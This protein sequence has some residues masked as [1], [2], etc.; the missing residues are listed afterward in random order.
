MIVRTLDSA[1]GDIIA[2]ARSINRERIGWGDRFFNEYQR[3]AELIERYPQL[4]S[5]VEDGLPPHEIRNAIF[6]RFDY[7]LIYVVRADEAVILAVTHT[8][9]RPRHWHHRLDEL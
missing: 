4:Y 8:S 2:V 9:R 7:R 1:N 5:P 6:A 3:I